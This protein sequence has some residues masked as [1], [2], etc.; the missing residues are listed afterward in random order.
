RLLGELLIHTELASVSDRFKFWCQDI[1]SVVENG[2]IT[3][4]KTRKMISR[5]G[6]KQVGVMTSVERGTLVTMA[7]DYSDKAELDNFRF[8]QK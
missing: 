1:Y 7:F 6:T 8:G 2:M 4:Q 3:V 5:K